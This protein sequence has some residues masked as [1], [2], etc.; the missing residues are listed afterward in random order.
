MTQFAKSNFFQNS[1]K[2]LTRVGLGGE[3]ILRTTKQKDLA[4]SV[5]KEACEQGITYFDTAR[6]Y[7]DSEIYYGN[8]WGNNPAHRETIFHT[9]KSAQRSRKGAMAEL[10][11]TLNRLN[12]SYLDLWQ[13]HDVRDER[14]L[15]LISR[16]GGALEAFLEA[17]ELGFVKHIGVTGHHDPDILRQAVEQWPVDAVLMPVNPV[18]EIIGGF[19]TRTLEA[20]KRKGIAV[21]GMK[22]LGGKHY[23][24]KESNITAG[25]LTRFALTYDITTAIVGCS[26][27]DEVKELADAGRNRNYLSSAEKKEIIRLFSP[28]AKRLAFYRG[29][30]FNK[31]GL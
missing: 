25:L 30:V 11:E 17:K 10:A 15:D 20:A 4:H 13:I 7:M 12:T 23:I 22:V 2:R 27:P 29:S 8:Y 28:Q 21:I 3:G 24:A 19:L 18:E 16:K 14:D 9:S 31:S 6:V 5:I 26:N 1:K